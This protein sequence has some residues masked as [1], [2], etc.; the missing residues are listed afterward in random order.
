MV[1]VTNQAGIARGYFSEDVLR[2]GERRR[3]CRSSTDE[4][5]YLDGIYVCPIIRP[6]A[7]RPTGWCA[8][9][10]SPSPGLLLRAAAELGLDLARSIAGR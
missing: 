2:R 6:R 1:V 4:G 8:T 3:S 5:A 10:A 9:A 7:S